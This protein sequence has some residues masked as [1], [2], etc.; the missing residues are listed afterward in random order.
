M[1]C[2]DASASRTAADVRDLFQRLEES[3]IRYVILRNYEQLFDGA[4]D[5]AS[6]ATDIDLVI[7]SED[8][9]KWRKIA[10]QFAADGE[11]DALTEC[12]HF[13]Q[14]RERA[15][16]IEIFRFYNYAERR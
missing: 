7:A 6:Q 3:G 4:G 10:A 14:S 16:H 15:H 1:T 8:I 12:S 5:S 2:V 11:W 13:R 9:P